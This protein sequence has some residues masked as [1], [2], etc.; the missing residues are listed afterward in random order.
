MS[1]ILDYIKWRGDL[2]FKESPFNEVDNLILS[3]ITY[4]NLTIAK[5]EGYKLSLKEVGNKYLAN[6]DREQIGLLL[7]GEFDKLMFLASNSRRFGNIII[8]DF[9]NVIDLKKEMQFAA[10]VFQ[11]DEECAYIGYRGTDDTVIGWKED[12]KMTFTDIVPAQSRAVAY[13]KE[14]S[15]RFNYAKYYIGGHSKGGNLAVYAATQVNAVFKKHIICIYNNDGPGLN[16]QSIEKEEYKSIVSKITTIVPQSSII[17]MMLEHEE[18]YNVVQSTGLGPYQHD[19]FSWEVLGNSFLTLSQVDDDSRIMNKTIRDTLNTMSTEQ[20]E[21]FTSALFEILTVDKMLTLTEIHENR[22]KNW[23]IMKKNYKNLDKVSKKMI[24]DVIGTFLN[25]GLSN[26]IHV[27]TPEQ[28]KI[29][30]SKW[31]HETNKFI[32]NLMD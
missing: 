13:L 3:E 16:K 29:N 1:N 17:G 9:T 23:M 8:K 20:R 7:T 26:F 25:S 19:G 27:K 11:L 14:I 22:L 28:W 5:E 21:L 12:F 24:E 10:I 31:C 32:G 30:Y 4:M 15:K 18:A 2:N 6:V